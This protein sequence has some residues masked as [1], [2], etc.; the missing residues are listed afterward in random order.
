VFFVAWISFQA[1]A[2]LDLKRTI[3]NPLESALFDSSPAPLTT[4]LS[5]YTA[6]LAHWTAHLLSANNSPGPAE[7]TT[8]AS[9]TTHI[10]LLNLT[11]INH[12]PPT[13]STTSAILAYLEILPPFLQAPLLIP[14]AP[15]PPLLINHLL[16]TNPSLQTLSRVSSLLAALKH[17]FE[18]A[19][20][21]L[22]TPGAAPP[23]L[24]TP[25][26]S[27]RPA[28]HVR[29]LNAELIDTCNLFFRSRAFNT[30]E[31]H[32]LGCLLPTGLHGSLG[33]Y[34]ASL[35][36]PHSLSGLFSLSHHASLMGLTDAAFR[37]VEDAAEGGGEELRVRHAGP[38]TQK[39]LA[40]LGRQG[41]VE[42]G[43]KD[44]RVLMLRWMGG[45]G[46]NGLGELGTA[47]MR[48]LMGGSRESE[49]GLAKA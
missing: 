20:P 11:L 46:V 2:P 37:E 8:I 45:M 31:A 41:G 29:D 49:V 39:S 15:P 38:V 13:T 48:G 4:L 26:T 27:P 47:T 28:E 42:V 14:L 34:T 10:Y 9:L 30:T 44:Y 18:P 25:A 1:N 6:L 3:L 7:T 19:S 36:P 16:F 12:T 35:D 5:F 23:P 32:T 21:A 43:W 24:T 17:A 33:K 40:Q 22:H